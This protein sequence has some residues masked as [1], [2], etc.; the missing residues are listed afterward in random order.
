M[1]RSMLI[2]GGSIIVLGA[3][4]TKSGVSAR[5]D[6]GIITEDV[7]DNEKVIPPH[8]SYQY[9]TPPCCQGSRVEDANYALI[10]TMDGKLIA[11]DIAKGGETVWEIDVERAPLLSGTLGRMAPME[12]NGRWYSL[13]PAL[14][15]SLYMYSRD[16][17]LLEPIPLNTE[18]LLQS[19]VR[20]AQDAVAGGRTVTTTGVDPLTGEI[21]YHCTANTCNNANNVDVK[22]TLV[23]RRSTNAVRAVNALTGAERWNLSVSEYDASLVVKQSTVSS[24]GV[25]NNRVRILVQPPEG[26]VTAYDMCGNQLWS[27]QVG[28]HIVR[29]WKLEAAQLSE[30]SLFDSENIHTLAVVDEHGRPPQH[31]AESLFYLGTMNNEPFIMHSHSVK[32]DLKRIARSALDAAEV[33]HSPGSQLIRA[34]HNAYFVQDKTIDDLLRFTIGKSFAAQSHSDNRQLAIQSSHELTVV[35]PE[36]NDGHSGSCPGGDGVSLIGEKDIRSA[37]FG[38][39]SGGDQGWFVMRPGISTRPTPMFLD[40]TRQCAVRFARSM[41]EKFDSWWKTSVAFFA[42][43]VAG[44]ATTVAIRYRRRAK[45]ALVVLV[46]A[47]KPVVETREMSS[48]PSVAGNPE[49]VP[50]SPSET[51]PT[52]VPVFRRER[53]T[54]SSNLSSSDPYQSKFLNDFEPVKLL[55]HGGFGLVFKARNRLDEGMYAVKRISVDDNENAIKRVLREVRA[56]AKL[57]HNGIIRYYHTWIERPPPGW[58]EESDRTTMLGIKSKKRQLVREEHVEESSR[59]DDE[60]ENN[61]SL[62]EQSIEAPPM[63]EISNDGSWLEDSASKRKP[64]SSDDESDTTESSDDSESSG[65]ES[66]SSNPNGNASLMGNDLS[67]GIVFGS[68]TSSGSQEL[69]EAP[70]IGTQ[71]VLVTSGE[72]ELLPSRNAK[73]FVYL[74]I[75]MQLCQEK[76]LHSWLKQ[77]KRPECRPVNKMKLWLGQLC[78]AVNY[79]HSQGLI[80]RD[81]KPQNIFFSAENHLKVGD[82][83]LVTKVFAVDEEPEKE[84]RRDSTSIHTDNVGT[85][86]YMSP[87]QISN[88]AYTFKVDVFSL[89]LIFCELIVP[90]QTFMERS[91]TLGDLQRGQVPPILEKYKEDE[92]RMVLWMTKMSPSERPSTEDI[93]CSDYL[94]EVDYD[95]PSPLGS[96]RRYRSERSLSEGRKISAFF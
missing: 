90:F 42:T 88:K 68:G 21:R 74:Y 58:Q 36:R 2:I 5:Y 15:G 12:S 30:I 45:T 31:H 76:T 26:I 82:L 4:L 72:E 51:T 69:K 55:G 47:P 40:K 16:D 64:D 53:R 27:R 28:S 71:M 93:L 79:I 49:S 11:L 33:H 80:H 39:G 96:R 84:T 23:F 22:S 62:L 83:G 1:S 35:N 87:E 9:T 60:K 10:S 67:D 95:E 7:Y 86:G 57:D 14:D 3:L 61:N 46:E 24:H 65:E 56:M 13:V 54:T 18:I 91:R 44:I 89:G 38:D 37:A 75:Q 17:R 19:S 94:A 70:A 78:S 81:L 63:P 20:I 43:L 77:N 59:A 52:T 50:S 73:N 8:E 29:S 6:D 34:G 92:K 41:E 66:A 85:R 25:T 48:G 32:A